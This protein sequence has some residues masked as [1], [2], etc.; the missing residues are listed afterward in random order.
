MK[1]VSTVSVIL[2][3][4]LSFLSFTSIGGE[5]ATVANLTILHTNDE[6]SAVIPFDPAI[7][8]TPDVGDDP[9]LGG[10]ARLA[11]EIYR[12]RDAKA[13]ENEPVLTLSAGDFLMGT[14][15]SWVGGMDLTPELTL[16]QKMGYDAVTIGNHEFDWTSD[17]LASYLSAAGYP[18]AA[19]LMPIVSSNINITSGHPLEAIGIQRY[20]IEELSNGLEVG[21]FGIIGY[22]A[23]FVSPM[24]GI[25]FADPNQTA[26]EM[27]NELTA[28][29]VDLIVCLSHSGVEEDKGLAEYAR[30]HS[31]AGI[32]VIVGGHTHD[33]LTK[34]E[35]WADTIIVQAGWGGLYLGELEL[36]V[37][38]SENVVAIRNYELIPINDSVSESPSIKADI[39]SKYIPQLKLLLSSLT[40]GK[41]NEILDVVAESEF[42]LLQPPLVET[43]LGNLI[44]DSIR[45]A[46][47]ADFAFEANG[48]I[49][50][51]VFAGTIPGKEGLISLYDLHAAVGLGIGPDELP[52]YPV[53]SF[54]LTAEEIRRV[55]E[56]SVTLSDLMGNTYFLHVSGLKFEYN[57]S[58]IDTFE[59]VTKIDKYV[60]SGPQNDSASYETLYENGEWAV[61]PWETLYNVAGNL[62]VTFFLPAIG[63]GLPEL[64][65]VPKDNIGNP[66]DPIDAIVHQH[67]GS[68]L[69]IW[70]AVLN[71][72][73]SLPDID[74]DDIPNIPL[75]FDGP[76]ERIMRTHIQ[77]DLNGDGIVDIFDVVTVS[78]AFGSTPEDSNWNPLADLNN[79]KAVDIFDVVTVTS[80]FGNTA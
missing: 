37:D 23:I 78:V 51:S 66:I 72:V 10:F 25:P 70:Q 49:R 53:T 43:G 36:S 12:I 14:M 48:V 22:D 2:V 80:N 47:S 9:T 61:D 33:A 21:I 71:Y 74:A 5:E 52:G 65:V 7:D 6:H 19:T 59:A 77:G 57:P 11:T 69:K 46:T 54:Y 75:W 60:G 4:I 62:Y 15:F 24:A 44:T 64:T 18:N 35:I 40:R 3:L 34:P 20:I 32:D 26:A 38:L 28:L 76:M 30:A 31:V 8:Y 68:E 79:D 58:L 13:L 41:F 45:A 29:G 55:C 39:D 16:M 1:S 56:I 42:D 73:V 17:Y 27:V 63:E 67:G 50:G